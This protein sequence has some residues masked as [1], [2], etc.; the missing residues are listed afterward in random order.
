MDVSPDKEMPMRIITVRESLPYVKTEDLQAIVSALTEG[1]CLVKLEEYSAPISIKMVAGDDYRLWME[2]ESSYGDGVCTQW[3]WKG[4][5]GY[6]I[7]LSSDYK[8]SLGSLLQHEL[9]HAVDKERGL[10]SSPKETPWSE[11]IEEK[12]AMMAQI[13]WEMEFVGSKEKSPTYRNR[14]AQYPALEEVFSKL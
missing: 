3:S 5:V 6:D 14:V 11:K 9:T 7:L 8:G 4:V 10:P 1:S 12:R 13:L 2:S